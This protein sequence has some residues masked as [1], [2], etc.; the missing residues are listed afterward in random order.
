MMRAKRLAVVFCALFVAAACDSAT[1]SVE[2]TDVTGPSL[3][4]VNTGFFDLNWTTFDEC[5]GED[6]D[7]VTKR[8]DVFNTTFDEAG[9]IH[10]GWHRTWVGKGVGQVTGTEYILNW[11]WQRQFYARGPFPETFTQRVNNNLPSK[12]DADNRILS[13]TDHVTVNANGDVTADVFDFTLK[14][15]G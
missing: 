9:G 11:P 15:V 10:M 8:K 5:T 14:C 7:F 13:L 3:A 2:P 1:K 4:V 12:G 6:V